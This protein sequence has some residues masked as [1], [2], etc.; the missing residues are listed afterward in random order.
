MPA[1]RKRPWRTGGKPEKDFPEFSASGTVPAAVDRDCSGMTDR[2][3]LNRA[4]PFGRLPDVQ[5]IFIPGSGRLPGSLLLYPIERVVRELEHEDF[6]DGSHTGMG[7]AGSESRDP[8][9]GRPGIPIFV[10]DYCGIVM[11]KKER[12]RDL[13]SV[14]VRVRI[15]NLK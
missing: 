12:S 10:P 2:P 8:P 1:G 14:S 9:T 4:D 6:R 3:L 15:R 7:M 13:R 5:L 11:W